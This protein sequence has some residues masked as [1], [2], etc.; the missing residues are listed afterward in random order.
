MVMRRKA[1]SRPKGLHSIVLA[2]ILCP[3]QIRPVERKDI[4]QIVQL[5]AWHAEYEMADFDPDNKEQL[6]VEHLFDKS[7]QI[8]C[9]VA[10]EDDR[11]IG[12]AT[13][14]KQFS[15]WDAD[16]YLYLDCLYLME[17]HRGKGWGT[18][19]MNRIKEHA[20]SENCPAIQWQTPVFNTK[21]IDFYRKLGAESKT[22]ERFT[23]FV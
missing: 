1:Q 23:W 6:L 5:C 21:A 20:L 12:Y 14:I 3:M 19:I 10:E 9:L 22:K 11:L 17:N 16:Y 8:R 2:N 4:P 13:F 15:T 7:N 18:K